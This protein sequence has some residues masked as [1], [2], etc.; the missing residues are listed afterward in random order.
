MSTES[1]D[2]LAKSPVRM[3]DY[4]ILGI[5]WMPVIFTVADFKFWGICLVNISVRMVIS[6]KITFQLQNIFFG[7]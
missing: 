5:F 7:N 1:S 6:R 4:K 3:T 2:L